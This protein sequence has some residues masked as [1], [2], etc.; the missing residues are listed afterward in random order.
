MTQRVTTCETMMSTRNEDLVCLIEEASFEA[1]RTVKAATANDTN[2][3]N[4]LSLV[5]GTQGNHVAEGQHPMNNKPEIYGLAYPVSTLSVSKHGYEG[6]SV[7][8]N[9]LLQYVSEQNWSEK[10]KDSFYRIS[11]YYEMRNQ[12]FVRKLKQN[13]PKAYNIFSEIQYNFE[14]KARYDRLLG[15]QKTNLILGKIVKVIYTPSRVHEIK[16]EFNRL[17]QR[18]DQTFDSFNRIFERK[19]ALLNQLGEQVDPESAKWSVVNA[20]NDTYKDFSIGIVWNQ[21]TYY[22][23]KDVLRAYDQRLRTSKSKFRTGKRSFDNSYQRS[24][25][26]DR[27]NDSDLHVNKKPRFFKRAT[28]SRRESTTRNSEVQR[29]PLLCWNCGGN[30]HVSTDCRK[31]RA[32]PPNPFRPKPPQVRSVAAIQAHSTEQEMVEVAEDDIKS[33][34][35][36]VYMLE[37]AEPLA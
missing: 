5:W 4:I 8:T 14:E 3:W 9:T 13:F 24:N 12:M 11:D 23:V 10:K 37:E 31:P 28:Y 25:I 33:G 20:L 2:Y 29:K 27:R 17:R 16:S 18:E 22:E 7:E 1:A 35:E 26:S 19:R 36:S 32:D 30:G 6:P 15:Y 34:E 21:M